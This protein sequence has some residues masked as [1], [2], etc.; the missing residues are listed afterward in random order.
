MMVDLPAPLGPTMPQR[1]PGRTRKEMSSSTTCLSRPWRMGKVLWMFSRSKSFIGRCLSSCPG[2]DIIVPSPWSL[3]DP[4]QPLYKPCP[5][6]RWKPNRSCT[7][8]LACSSLRL[9]RC[10]RTTI[11]KIDTRVTAP[12]PVIGRRSLKNNP[13]TNQS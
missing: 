11:L 10:W 6:K 8:Y 2:K 4:V 12:S 5:R 13:L 1:S 3:R 7:W 9:C